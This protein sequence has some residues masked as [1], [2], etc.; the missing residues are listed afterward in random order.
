MGQGAHHGTRAGRWRR[1]EQ[2]A[3]VQDEVNAKKASSDALA[4]AVVANTPAV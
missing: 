2:F 4:V 3:P 1:G